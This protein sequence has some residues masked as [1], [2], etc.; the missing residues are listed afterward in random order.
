MA[1]R[2]QADSVSAQLVTA[3]LPPLYMVVDCEKLAELMPVVGE[4]LNDV[5]L[6]G[7]DDVIEVLVEAACVEPI[8]MATARKHATA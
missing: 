8:K 3:P 6:E 7:A 2:Q 5:G 4:A 1:T